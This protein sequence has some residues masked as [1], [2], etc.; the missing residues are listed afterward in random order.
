MIT[1]LSPSRQINTLL[2]GAD[3]VT[4]LQTHGPLTLTT[5]TTPGPQGP[6]GASGSAEASVF[7]A[8]EN[9]SGHALIKVV[10]GL[11]Y[12]C[13][14]ATL[15]DT[16]KAIGIATGAVSVGGNVS[17]QQGGQLT[18]PS[19]SWTEG[20]VYVGA[21]GFLTQNLSGLLYLHQIGVALSATTINIAPQMAVILA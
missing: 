14:A 10:G 1:V 17:V 21:T 13:D 8:G 20:P 11:A 2:T 9:I 3:L 7:V 16:G 18:E 5:L 15:G 4:G 19:W 6:A 12:Q